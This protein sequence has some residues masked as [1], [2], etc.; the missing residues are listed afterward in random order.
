MYNDA[1]LI[2]ATKKYN[3]YSVNKPLVD[4]HIVFVPKKETWQSLCHCFEAAYKWGYDWVEKDYCKS[5][6]VIQNVGEIAGNSNGN[7]VYLIP[8]QKSDKINITKVKDF[9]NFV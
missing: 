1:D 7:L 8:R 6:H 2:V 3:V 4:G 5:F 9:F